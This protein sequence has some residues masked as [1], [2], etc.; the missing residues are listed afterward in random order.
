QALILTI[1]KEVEGGDTLADALRKHSKQFD[2]L[3]CGLVH[4]GAQSGTLEALLDKIA[5]YK[6]KIAALKAKVKKALFYPIAVVIV[7]FIITTILLLFVIPQFQIL[8]QN[9]DAD[10]PP[11]TLWVLK[12]SDLF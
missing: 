10:L 12:L 6:E 5:L 4:A 2:K 8:F 3:S 9:F 11:L 1:K 7:A